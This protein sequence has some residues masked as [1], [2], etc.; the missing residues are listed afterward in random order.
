MQHNSRRLRGADG[1]CLRTAENSSAEL[2]HLIKQY[3][4]PG[5]VVMDGCCGTMAGAM[6]CL[7]LGRHGVFGDID[8]ETATAGLNRAM[9][10]FQWLRRTGGLLRQQQHQCFNILMLII[11]SFRWYCTKVCDAAVLERG[12]G[13]CIIASN[14]SLSR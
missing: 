12:G 4:P 10:Y 8:K 11:N 6:S 9:G 13:L 5:G 2:S 7:A 3:C 14:Q 1:K